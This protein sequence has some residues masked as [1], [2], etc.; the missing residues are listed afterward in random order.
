[1]S[2][3]D[4][5]GEKDKTSDF[6]SLSD[7]VSKTRPTV[8]LPVD[9]RQTGK[10]QGSSKKIPS[11]NSPVVQ[12]E[13]A[14]PLTNSE[15]QKDVNSASHPPVL[16]SSISGRERRSQGCVPKKTTVNPKSK[17]VK[18]FLLFYYTVEV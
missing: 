11:K 9:T 7:D 13:D 5:Y 17:W 12:E 2:T 4:S 8:R 14:S 16:K 10:P 15:V 18:F 1:M 3:Q 6:G